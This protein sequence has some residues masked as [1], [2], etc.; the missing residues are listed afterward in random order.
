MTFY[1]GPQYYFFGTYGILGCVEI[2]DLPSS[3][4]E[5][6]SYALSS[7]QTLFPAK[8]KTVICRAEVPPSVDY[9]IGHDLYNE[10]DTTSIFQESA[11]LYVPRASISAYQNSEY[12]AWH[13]FK[14]I[15]AIED[16][17]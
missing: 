11:T 1:P 8:C 10:I 14:E 4:T 15:K 13:E 2:I 17:Q 6:G 5:I 16:M 3:L 9:Y 12:E 7:F